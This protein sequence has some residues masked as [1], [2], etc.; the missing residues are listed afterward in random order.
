MIFSYFIS[1]V[2]RGHFGLTIVP[3]TVS[4]VLPKDTFVCGVHSGSGLT[5]VGFCKHRTV[6][7][8][9]DNSII[10][11]GMTDERHKLLDVGVL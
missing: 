4:K 2:P 3:M 11:I 9:E 7:G 8:S 10:I 6:Q 1:C 5:I